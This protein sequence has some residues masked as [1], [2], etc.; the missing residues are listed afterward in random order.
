MGA[1]CDDVLESVEAR[2]QEKVE[3][4]HCNFEMVR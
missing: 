2:Q 1:L 3:A 4:L